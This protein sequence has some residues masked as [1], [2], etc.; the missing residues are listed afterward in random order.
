MPV[1]Q[2]KESLRSPR[3]I[4]NDLEAGKREPKVIERDS[5]CP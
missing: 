1:K 4:L 5:Q 2:K 3:K